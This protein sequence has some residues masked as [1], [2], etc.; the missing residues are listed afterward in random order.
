MTIQISKVGDAHLYAFRKRRYPLPRFARKYAR[1]DP[2]KV[3]GVYSRRAGRIRSDSEMKRVSVSVT[4]R[5]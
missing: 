1:Q 3:A 2:F 4:G 5:I